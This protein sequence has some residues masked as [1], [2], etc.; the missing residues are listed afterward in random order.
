MS[1]RTI[2]ALLAVASL[3]LAAP[4]LAGAAT[5]HQPC[6]KTK[7]KHSHVNCGKHLGQHKAKK[8]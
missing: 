3:T 4:S 8:A 1:T 6:G 2:P 5:H 7:A